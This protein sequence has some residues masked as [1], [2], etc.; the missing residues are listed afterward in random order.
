MFV[1]TERAIDGQA[2]AARPFTLVTLRSSGLKGKSP[3][4]R[5]A[6]LARLP[7]AL[8]QAAGHILR[9][10][11]MVVLGVG[12]YVTGP[13][14]LAARLLGRPTC[15]HEQ[16]SIP[17]MTNRILARVVQRVCVSIPGSEQRFP[18]KKTVL[19]GNPVRKELA[20][21]APEFGA[22]KEGTTLLVLGG[23]QGAH[24]VNRL[25]VEALAGQ[26]QIPNNFRVIHQTG[27]LDEEWVR[28][29]YGKLGIQA[30][31]GAFFTDMAQLYRAADLVVSRAGATTLAELALLGKPVIMIPYPHAADNHQ[32]SNGQ[33][34]VDRGAARMFVE[35][36]MDGGR[37]GQE[38]MG[39]LGDSGA[40]E[41]MARAIHALAKPD[42]A[43]AI[44]DQCLALAGRSEGGT[45]SRTGRLD[46]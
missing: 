32:E 27:H 40:R 12:G 26:R 19:T 2:L 8:L 9:F 31:V 38:I 17:G 15:I 14:L 18:A 6:A 20:G 41:K 11:P 4:D 44:V 37:L 36:E 45:V 30:R 23:S 39:L 24:R 13:V 29:E 22:G 42:A 1:S 43:G 16:N 34:L 10:K 21:I 25:V 3:V 5:L 7:L 28:E 46:V 35:R 33:Y